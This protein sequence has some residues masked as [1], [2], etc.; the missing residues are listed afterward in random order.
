MTRT[1]ASHMAEFPA[2]SVAVH[3]TVND[4]GA[5]N[6]IGA[7]M[8]ILAGSKNSHEHIHVYEIK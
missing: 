5:S 1:V 8:S 2:K 4:S 3:V 7:V 6:V